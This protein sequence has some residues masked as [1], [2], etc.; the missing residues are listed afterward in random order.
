MN[1]YIDN[2]SCIYIHVCVDMCGCT[3]IF[4][5]RNMFDLHWQRAHALRPSIANRAMHW[6]NAGV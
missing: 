6:P 3:H 5:E 1:I 2:K 4:D